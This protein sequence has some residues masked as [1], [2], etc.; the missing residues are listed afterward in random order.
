MQYSSP[1]HCV[2]RPQSLAAA[3]AAVPAAPC[4][5]G[6]IC[7][8]EPIAGAA[9]GLPPAEDAALPAVPI[10]T[11]AV[12]GEVDAAAVPVLAAGLVDWLALGAPTLGPDG[13]VPTTGACGVAAD[14]PPH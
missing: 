14:W 9:A 6:C 7:D 13:A 3:I 2:C 8:A 5:A 1:A 4:C 12:A 10:A 11:G